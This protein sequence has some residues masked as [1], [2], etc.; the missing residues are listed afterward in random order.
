M[1]PCLGPVALTSWNSMVA[2]TQ[3]MRCNNIWWHLHPCSALTVTLCHQMHCPEWWLW[4]AIIKTAL[5]NVGVGWAEA[6]LNLPG[7]DSK[8]GEVA[9]CTKVLMP[10]GLTRCR[11]YVTS[12][13]FCLLLGV[14]YVRVMMDDFQLFPIISY[15]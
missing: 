10:E 13:G 15:L 6:F 8:K 3:F 4:C 1:G 5:A 11:R 12:C 9:G 2:L 14:M 7:Q